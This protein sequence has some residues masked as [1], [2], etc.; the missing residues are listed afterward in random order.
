MV[1]RVAVSSLLAL[2]SLP[3]CGQVRLDKLWLKTGEQ[4]EVHASDILVI[5]TLVMN[6]S[7]RIVFRNGKTQNFIHCKSATL[8]KGAIVEA[9]GIAGARGEKGKN[10][11]NSNGPCSNGTN[12]TPGKPGEPGSS[13]GSIS[14][15][16]DHLTLT[17]RFIVSIPGGDGGDGGEGGGGGRGASGASVSAGG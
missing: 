7:S 8:G 9:E 14:L 16:W 13:G 6:D 15:Y 2:M 3:V 11:Q 1:Y 4:Y 12:A 10:G 5:D 17:G